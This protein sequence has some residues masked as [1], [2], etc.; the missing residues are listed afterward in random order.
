MGTQ[1]RAYSKDAQ[2]NV[3]G[4]TWHDVHDMVKQVEMLTGLP[5]ELRMRQVKAV[6]GQLGMYL[7]C[8][9]A[10]YEA[11]GLGA[12]FGPAYPNSPKTYPAAAYS[13]LTRVYHRFEADG[14]DAGKKWL[15]AQTGDP[16]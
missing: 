11:Q 1:Q 8:W 9:L 7:T 10:G 2:P 16:F 6:S 14:D 5:C 12:G 15:S 3:Y 4:P 13:V